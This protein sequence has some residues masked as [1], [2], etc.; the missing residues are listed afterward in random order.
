MAREYRPLHWQVEV[1]ATLRDG[2]T[3]HILTRRHCSFREGLRRGHTFCRKHGIDWV[4]LHAT[5]PSLGTMP[6]ETLLPL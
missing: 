4:Q 2:T 6:T 5:T 3:R 1:T